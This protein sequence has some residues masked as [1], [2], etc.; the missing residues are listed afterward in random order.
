MSNQSSEGFQR[1]F[2]L[3]RRPYSESSLI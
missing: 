3:H 1:C 2:V